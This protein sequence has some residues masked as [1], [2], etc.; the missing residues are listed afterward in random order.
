MKQSPIQL[1]ESFPRKM[2]VEEVGPDDSDES[3]FEKIDLQIMRGIESVPQFWEEKPPLSGLE[4][5]TYRVTLGVRTPR[6][7][8]AGPY[9]FEFILS[10]IF[11]CMA[12]PK[13]K[14]CED[15]AYE[16]GLTILYGNIR[17]HFA[18]ISSRM[19]PGVRFLP[20]LSFLGETIPR[21]RKKLTADSAD[22]VKPTNE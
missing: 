17:E 10:G 18:T 16:Y 12:I 13:D 14:K 5:R 6:D 15:M 1:L 21:Q 4:N 2:L 8:P 20:T 22:D 19:E 3:A 7:K 9:E 11:A